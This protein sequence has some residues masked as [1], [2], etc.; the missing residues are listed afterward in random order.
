MKPVSIRRL[1]NFLVIVAILENA[2]LTKTSSKEVRRRLESNLNCDLTHRKKEID[3]LVMD[4]VEE[5]DKD[6]DSDSTTEEEEEKPKRAVQRKASKKS[7]ASEDSASDSDDKPKKS[8]AKAKKSRKGSDSDSDNDASW[9][10]EKKPAAKKAKPAAKGATKG[11]GTGFTRPYKLST[12]LASIVGAPELPRHEVVKKMWEIIKG[13]NL[14]D[15]K[16]KQFAICD[17]Q[18]QTVIGVKRFRTFAMLKYLK[19]HFLD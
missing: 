2:D 5:Q 17:E 19:P 1:V 3:N 9:K 13:R 12:E 15:P 10:R 8:A 6:S 11:R 16:N 4:Y 18:L 14:Y 7:K